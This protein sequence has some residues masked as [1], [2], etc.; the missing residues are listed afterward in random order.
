MNFIL[1]FF[2]RLIY[3]KKQSRAEIVK[4]K[5]IVIHRLKRVSTSFRLLNEF[6]QVNNSQKKLD[7]FE[8]R[9]VYD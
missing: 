3:A 6:L 8:P 7:R 4:H 1:F 9:S 5:S 2:C